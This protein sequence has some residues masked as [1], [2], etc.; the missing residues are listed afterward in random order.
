LTPLR[1]FGT[2]PG[3]MPRSSPDVEKLT[4]KSQADLVP[5]VSGTSTFL[6]EKATAAAWE[7]LA[8]KARAHGFDARLASAFRHYER[9]LTLWNEKADGK[10]PLLDERGQRI[11]ARGLEPEAL[12]RAILLWSAIPGASRH[13]WGTDV[14]VF[15]AA[16]VPADYRVELT[17]E[18]SET[19]FGEFHRWLDAEASRFGFYRP[20]DR[21]RGG[22]KPERWHLSYGPVASAY[23]D[24][25]TR[26]VFGAVLAEPR[27]R[28]GDVLSRLRDE[29]YDRYV[30]GIAEYRSA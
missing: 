22:V 12:A 25:Y 21:D 6:L 18:E 10:R 11:D 15:D 5:V 2:L 7:T 23:L 17:P 30:L 4:G 16:A 29:L 28:L 19:R 20:Y 8:E 24:S 3:I 14:D 1:P 27:L 13:H 26:H 9:Q